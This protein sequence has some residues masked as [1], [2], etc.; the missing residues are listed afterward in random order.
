MKKLLISFGASDKESE[1]FLKMLE[2]GAQPISVVAA[3]VKIPRPSMYVVFERLKKLKLVEE[4]EQFGIKYIKCISIEDFEDLIKLKEK[5]LEQMSSMLSEKKPEFL[6]L[7]NQ[8]SS[9][10]LIRFFQGKQ[11]VMKMYEEILRGGGFCATFNPKL[12]KKMMP[13]Y[14]Y[15]IGETLKKS[16]R[17]ARELLVDCKEAHEYKKLFHSTRHEIK[18]LP[19]SMTFDSDIIIQKE[20]LYMISYGEVDLTGTEII[21]KSLAQ[22]QQATFDFLWK[23]I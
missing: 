9:K 12:V 20:K 13:E 8:L 10:P 15:K 23:K 4:F 1:I 22:T 18:T 14:H 19:P 17:K 11:E 21:N 6:A 7:E 16:K 2:L 3:Q 5:S